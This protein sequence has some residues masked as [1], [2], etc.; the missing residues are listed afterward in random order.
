MLFLSALERGV[1]GEEIKAQI[2]RCRNFGIPLTHIDSHYH[3]HIELGVIN[4]L[5][6]IAKEENI[7]FIRI[8]RNCGPGLT[9]FLQK[10]LYKSFFNR[11][12]AQ[13]EL[14]RTKYFGS[15]ND[16]LFFKKKQRDK[17]KLESFEISIHPALNQDNILIDS[18]MDR[19]LE[20]IMEKIPYQGAISFKRLGF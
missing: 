8:D 18:A 12:L 2:R 20:E 14:A 19:P 3:S 11:R 6:P 17:N 10:K 16:Y 1:L 7:P 15:I 5:V 4:V 9:L 13:K